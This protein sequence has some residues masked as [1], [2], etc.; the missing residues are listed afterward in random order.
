[1][2][3][4]APAAN[5]LAMSLYELE[6]MIACSPTY[7][8]LVGTTDWQQARDRIA[9]TEEDPTTFPRPICTVSLEGH[10]FHQ[11]AGGV[12]NVLRASG[13]LWIYLAIDVPSSMLL[14]SGSHA[15][16]QS[17]QRK[18]QLQYASNIFGGFLQDL[19]AASGLDQTTDTDQIDSQLSAMKIVL[20]DMY[21]SPEEYWATVGQF[22]YLIATAHWGDQ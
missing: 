2:T 16:D 3:R 4:L 17:L 13:S 7:Q 21:H 8:S 1:M 12:Q 15:S 14:V 9:F 22:W 18:N 11:I 20:R 10:E 5:P 6:R 19:A